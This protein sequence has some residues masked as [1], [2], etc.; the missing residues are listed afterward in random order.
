MKT[1]RYNMR[2][3]MRLSVGLVAFMNLSK[4]G[5]T[6]FEVHELFASGNIT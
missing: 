1:F 4:T 6:L 3:A 5:A 2:S